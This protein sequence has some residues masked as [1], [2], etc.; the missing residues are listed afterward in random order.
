MNVTPSLSN[1][2]EIELVPICPPTHVRP[3]KSCNVG[4]TCASAVS[5]SA[6]QSVQTVMNPRNGLP[7][8]CLFLWRNQAPLAQDVNRSVRTPQANR[9]NVMPCLGAPIPGNRRSTPPSR[10]LVA[11]AVHSAE[12]HDRAARRPVATIAHR[13]APRNQRRGALAS[14]RIVH[15]IDDRPDAPRFA[16]KLLANGQCENLFAQVRH[17]VAKSDQLRC[18]LV[19]R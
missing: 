2:S 10:P 3:A 4:G 7:S 17:L 15:G 11:R 5:N 12:K 9:L 16:I 13:G 6:D 8:S 14:C 19:L 18:E 1:A